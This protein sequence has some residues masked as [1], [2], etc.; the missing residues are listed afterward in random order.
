[1]NLKE[2][3]D[4]TP[5]SRDRYVDFLRAASMSVV[6]LGHWLSALVGCKDGAVSVRNAVGLAP[7]LSSTTWLL[8]VM[9][10]FFFIGG[11]SDFTS[12]EGTTSR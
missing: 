3:A 6:V 8:Q 7:G 2:L 4:Q 5:A 9:P 11:F 10:L 12:I 1:V